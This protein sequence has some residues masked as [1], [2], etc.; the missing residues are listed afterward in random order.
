MPSTTSQRLCLQA[1]CPAA[2]SSRTRTNVN[3]WVCMAQARGPRIQQVVPGLDLHR[4]NPAAPTRTGGRD[5][6]RLV[7][8]RLRACAKR[9]VRH[10]SADAPPAGRPRR[11]APAG[12]Y[13]VRVPRNWAIVTRL[14]CCATRCKNAGVL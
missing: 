6:L 9:T 12:R 8:P 3:G 2:S 1:G 7:G 13:S 10:T 5:G 4:V 14:A 11:P